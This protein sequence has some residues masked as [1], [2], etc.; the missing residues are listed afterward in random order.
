MFGSYVESYT[1]I[2]G[3]PTAL[4]VSGTTTPRHMAVPAF[5]W[6]CQHVTDLWG[7]L[8]LGRAENVTMRIPWTWDVPALFYHLLCSVDLEYFTCLC[9]EQISQN[10]QT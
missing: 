7:V 4:G 6:Q 3:R 10:K 9:K 5:F 8:Y 1:K 2:P